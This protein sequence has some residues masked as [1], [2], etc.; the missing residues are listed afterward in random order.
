MIES[1]YKKEYFTGKYLDPSNGFKEK[2]LLF[3]VRHDEIT[4]TTCRILPMRFRIPVRPDIKQYLETSAQSKC[5]FCPELF[6]KITPRFTRNITENGKFQRGRAFLFPNA[7]PHASFNCVAIFSDKHFIGLNELTTDTMLDGFLV[8]QDYFKSLKEAG[9]EVRFCSINWNYMPP[10]GGGVVHP[11]IQTVAGQN[12]T[13]HVMNLKSKAHAYREATGNDLWI[14]LMAYEKKTDQRF[15]AN[16]G[17]IEWTVS[18]APRGMAGEI[19]FFF[20]AR[21]SIFDLTDDDYRELMQGLVA[22]F[23]YF[24]EKKFISFNMSLI[25]SMAKDDDLCVQGRLMPR[26][27]ILPL[28][29]S[30]VNYFEKLHNEVICPSIPED[31]CKELKPLF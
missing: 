7:F 16:T 28:G 26:Y 29:A 19:G 30:D 13:S 25:A 15:I 3:E 1:Y 8:C 22:L 6:E 27:I 4:A 2:E 21:R 5:P 23:R 14:D 20:T 12:P 17:N 9:C 10:A 11:H 18:F 24:D 31:I